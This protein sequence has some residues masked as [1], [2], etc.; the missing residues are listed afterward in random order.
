MRV[1]PKTRR[2]WKQR[3]LAGLRL[4]GAVVLL[5]LLA[6]VLLAYWPMSLAPLAE[7]TGAALSYADAVA[8]VRQWARDSGPDLQP[9]CIDQLLEHGYRTERAYVLLHGLSNC[10]AQF[11]R[12]GELLYGRGANVV[13]PR[14]PYHG[15]EDRLTKEWKELSA[16]MML[17]TADAAIRAAHGLGRKVTVVGL[18]VNGTVAAWLAQH[19]ADLDEV[20]L[21]APFLAPDGLREWMVAP[22]TRLILRL[23]NEFLW[24][25]R[26]KKAREMTGHAYPRFPTRALAQTMRF[27]LDVLDAARREPPQCGSILVVTTGYDRSSNEALTE[28]LVRRWS[29][30]RPG[31]VRTYEFPKSAQVDHDMIDPTHPRQH[32]DLV[33]PQ[34]LRLLA[35]PRQGTTLE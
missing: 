9:E 15:E 23:P 28:L 20:V 21:L 4:S 25:D 10:P 13:I 34:L 1:Q 32:I 8:Q 24:W 33:Y 19:R 18:S 11:R 29:A 30:L 14:L 3:L 17:H 6:V 22:A 27:S 2:P 35:V 31:I 5:L 12:F 7:R 16:E 26:K